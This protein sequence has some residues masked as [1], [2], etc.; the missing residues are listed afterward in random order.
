M[1]KSVAKFAFG[2]LGG[3]VVD[4]GESAYK[5]IQKSSDSGIE[6]L[7]EEVAKQQIKMGF[8]QSQARIEQELAIAKRI[9]NAVE[10]EIEEFYDN[11]NKGAG[12]LNA[13]LKSSTGG[14]NFSAEGIR[15]SKRIYKF[16]GKID[17]EFE[18]YEQAE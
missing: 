8:L 15:V 4:A 1:I 18:Q 11:S 3:M 14:L 9:A 13:D 16:R 12:G 2:P 17:A 7:K 5:A 10:V 6:S